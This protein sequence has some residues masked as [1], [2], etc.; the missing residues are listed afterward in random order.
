MAGVPFLLFP[1]VMRCLLRAFRVGEDRLQQALG[2]PR[3]RGSAQ[4]RRDISAATLASS[5]LSA[6]KGSTARDS[7][8]RVSA[9]EVPDTREREDPKARND[10]PDSRSVE[11]VGGA[12]LVCER[13]DEDESKRGEEHRAC[14]VVRAT[15]DNAC[16][17]DAAE[18]RTRSSCEVHSRSGDERQG[19]DRPH[20]RGDR[21]GD[22]YG[23]PD[24]QREEGSDELAVRSELD[25]RHAS[26]H[27]A[28]AAERADR[29]VGGGA[30]FPAPPRRSATRG[31]RTARARRTGRARSGRRRPTPRSAA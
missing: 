18:R 3:T 10:R 11:H 7:E 16:C 9:P 13:S 1:A 21:V 14:P 17:G 25:R 26:D 29:R 2:G 19:G 4:P 23:S 27:R 15:R 12:E 5:L 6:V 24:Q 22:Q 20:R 8:R 31:R 28:D 30:A